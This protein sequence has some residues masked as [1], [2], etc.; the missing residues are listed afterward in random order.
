M[1]FLMDQN[2]WKETDQVPPNVNEHICE[3]NSKSGWWFLREDFQSFLR[4][5]KEPLKKFERGPYKQH[6]LKYDGLGEDV[7]Y[8]KILCTKMVKRHSP[9]TTVHF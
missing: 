8:R 6:T 3:I 4:V 2:G 1:C 5:S 7:V 9:I